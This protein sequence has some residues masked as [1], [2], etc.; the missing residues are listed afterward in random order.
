MAHHLLSAW[1]VQ[2][3][4]RI[5]TGMAVAGWIAVMGMP[6]S[7]RAPVVTLE[8]LPLFAEDREIA[9]AIVGANDEKIRNWLASLPALESDG[10][11]KRHTV[12]GRYVPG[13][14]QFYERR[15]GCGL[16]KAALGSHEDE[17]PWP[18]SRGSQRRG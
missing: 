8:N 1:H 13:V 3:I 2:T 14:K 10:L 12:Y 7:R 6:M 5:A 16:S 11:P 15:Y 4:V 18:K 9:Q 17:K